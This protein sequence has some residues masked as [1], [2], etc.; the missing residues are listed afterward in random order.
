MTTPEIKQAILD[1]E[2]VY[3]STCLKVC[4]PV[5]VADMEVYADPWFVSSCC[6]DD[7]LSSEEAGWE[8]IRRLHMKDRPRSDLGQMA[9]DIGEIMMR[10]PRG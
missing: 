1:R 7:I 10:R 9:W 3:C 5:K 6:R 4:E 8:A 2:P